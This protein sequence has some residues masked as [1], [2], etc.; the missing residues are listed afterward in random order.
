MVS[1]VSG[2]IA[3]WVVRVPVAYWMAEHW[4]AENLF[5]SYIVGWSVGILISGIY[6]LSGK[7]TSKQMLRS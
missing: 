1:T 7:W 5:F 2:V 3:L 6:Y 4:G